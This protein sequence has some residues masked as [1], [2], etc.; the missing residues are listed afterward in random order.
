VTGFTRQGCDR[1]QSTGDCFGLC[2]EAP[3]ADEA[4]H[5]L[6]W[7]TLQL[8]TLCALVLPM[9]AEAASLSLD[10]GPIVLGRTQSVGI[11]VEMEEPPESADRPLRL[12]VN[13]GSF[14]PVTRTGPGKYR[15]IYEPPPTLYPQVALVALWRETGPDAPIEF[16]RIPLYGA[17]TVP[18]TSTPHAEVR[19][20]VGP[21]Q[22][23][24][25]RA[26]AKGRSEIPI[27]VPPGILEATIAATD[28]SSTIVRRSVKLKVPPYNR[29]TA[30][31]VPHAILADGKAWARIEVFYDQAGPETPA[32]RVRVAASIGSAVL[33]RAARQRYEYRYVSEAGTTAK[34]VRFGV[35]VA[36]DPASTASATLDLGLPE[37]ARAVIRPPGEAL[38]SDGKSRGTVSLFVFDPT[39]LALAGQS[40]EV[41]ANG[42]PLAKAVD[43]G[44]GQYEVPYVSPSV[45]PPGGLVQFVA[46]VRGTTGPPI[47]ASVNYQLKSPSLPKSFA[48]RVTPSPVPADARTE[49]TLVFDVRDAAGMPL[50]NAQLLV[51]ASHGTLGPLAQ[52]A[53]GDYQATYVAPSAPPPGDVLVRL[54]DS[55]GG[56][57]QAVAIPL[58][59]DPHRLM[60]GIRGGVTD[61]LGSLI[62]PRLGLDLW[63]PIRLGSQYFGVG[64]SATGG[65]ASQSL[66]SPNG[67]S[68]TGQATFVPVVLRVGYEFYAGRRLSGLLGAGAIASFARFSTPANGEQINRWGFGALGFVSGCFLIG[69]GQAFLELSYSRAP[70]SSTYFDLDTGGLGVE[71]GYRFAIL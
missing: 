11:T 6:P 35:S 71:V 27:I 68:L 55:T 57:D 61:S 13:V 60:L 20:E 31:L 50:K 3:G 48:V 29:L 38:V 21:D 2:E 4:I 26:D 8:L 51:V 1:K 12:S 66:T 42:Q 9:S 22:F 23:G 43:A 59:E 46:T 53:E 69:P 36:G 33:I 40:V 37:P 32:E 62:G 41:T 25:V 65:V 10:R 5:R 49:A 64:L 47:T 7:I 67:L 58:R 17:L 24:P 44:S 63:A 19:V 30:A 18:A 15:T 14:A 39:G 45:Y 52:T 28:K 56:F 16:L 54:V 70:V 34:M